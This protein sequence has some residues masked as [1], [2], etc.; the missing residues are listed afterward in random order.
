MEVAWLRTELEELRT[1]S[2]RDIEDLVQQRA[3]E[4]ELKA[5]AR[6]VVAVVASG[7][8]VGKVGETVAVATGMAAVATDPT[9]ISGQIGERKTR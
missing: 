4:Q 5:V 8:M 1:R 3:R 2:S 7:A 9:I 6:V